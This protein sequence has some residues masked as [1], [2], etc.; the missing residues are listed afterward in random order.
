MNFSSGPTLES[1]RV[2][3]W[4]LPRQEGSMKTKYALKLALAGLVLCLTA[5]GCKR[6][7]DDF[8]NRTL[9]KRPHTETVRPED[10]KDPFR[11]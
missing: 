4:M 3:F 6:S 5:V 8:D 2:V 7:E 10:K 1:G 9:E 11:P